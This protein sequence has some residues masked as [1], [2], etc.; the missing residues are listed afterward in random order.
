M[1]VQA[2]RPLLEEHCERPLSVHSRGRE[3]NA[4][5]THESSDAVGEPVID[6]LGFLPKA[7][8]LRGRGLAE[9]DEAAVREA[10]FIH[11][12]VQRGIDGIEFRDPTLELF[13][14]DLGRIGR[15]R[16][17]PVPNPEERL[18]APRNGEQMAVAPAQ[19]G[20]FVA[21]RAL[22]GE[23][24]GRR[25]RTIDDE[26]R[27]ARERR[28]LE[29]TEA[30]FVAVDE[31]G[32]RP[33]CVERQTRA[34]VERLA[35]QD[36]A[37]ANPANLRISPQIILRFE[38]I[39]RACTLRDG[40]LHEREHQPRGVVHLTVFKENGAAQIRCRKLRIECEQLAAR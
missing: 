34:N 15:C 13:G 26:V 25:R 1:N 30:R 31:I 17:V 28:A 4:D 35:R 38:V 10:H 36:I 18:V 32:P 5:E 37:C 11:R 21:A 39:A 16:P 23:R 14:C 9:R 6:Q 19:D 20:I 22:H 3:A 8:L 2:L 7:Q 29:C 40:R 24:D 33:G 12:Q 27:I